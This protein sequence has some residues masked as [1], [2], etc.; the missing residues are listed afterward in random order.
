MK[1]LLSPWWALITLALLVYTFASSNNFV[2]SIKL[3][4]FDTLIVN[5]AP[6]QNNIFVVEIDEAALERYGQYPFQET[7][8]QP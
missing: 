6:T 5:Q 7:Y 8:T 1:K 2:E 3:R 4:Y